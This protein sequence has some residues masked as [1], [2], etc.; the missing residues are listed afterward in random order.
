MHREQQHHALKGWA[1]SW[2]NWLLFYN[3]PQPRPCLVPLECNARASLPPQSQTQLSGP[4]PELPGSCIWQWGNSQ[5]G[6]NCSTA[7]Q[8]VYVHADT[9]APC[10][11]LCLWSPITRRHVSLLCA[12]FVPLPAVLPPFPYVFMHGLST[13]VFEA[14]W[15]CF[16]LFP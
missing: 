11:T 3:P 13:V 15:D 5:G 1:S 2:H 12:T 14:L 9:S 16:A 6:T 10:R 8:L 4:I 7:L